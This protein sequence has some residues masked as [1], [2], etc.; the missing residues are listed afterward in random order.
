MRNYI[1]IPLFLIGPI[2]AEEPK[3]VVGYTEFPVPVRS[4]S[5]LAYLREVHSEQC[6]ER[7][8]SGHQ[9]GD[10]LLLD[11]SGSPI[12][13][14]VS[15]FEYAS[16]GGEH[17]DVGVDSVYIDPDA[18]KANMAVQNFSGVYG[19]LF[20]RSQLPQI[21]SGPAVSIEMPT[22]NSKFEFNGVSYRLRAESVCRAISGIGTV[23]GYDADF[24]ITIEANGVEQDLMLSTKHRTDFYVY[25][26][27]DEAL[28]AVSTFVPFDVIG[29]LDRDGK[30]DLVFMNNAGGEL[31]VI[32]LSSLAGVGEIVK[33]IWL[34]LSC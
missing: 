9:A 23:G 12:W 15:R 14:E 5:A 29:D 19:V 32:Y 27:C 30:L 33:A 21:K 31:P 1:L 6:R 17:W 4:T 34:N 18:G 3:S 25:Q 16:L 28:K 22:L 11:L 10:Y 20:E 8:C 24:S 13:R 2:Q 26:T 7:E